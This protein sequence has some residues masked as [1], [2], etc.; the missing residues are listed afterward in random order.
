M[1][2]NLA[3]AKQIEG[4]MTDLEMDWLATIARQSKLVMEVGSFKGRS[5]R[6]I[7]DNLPPEGKLFAIDTWNGSEAEPDAHEACKRLHGDYVYME[8]ISNLS[9]LIYVGRVIP[10]RMH[11]KNAAS[12]LS[13][14]RADFIF[15]DASHL[16]EDVLVDIEAFEPLVAENGVFSGH[17]YS[18]GAHP[19]V[20]KAVDEKL[21]IVNVEGT[22]IWIRLPPPVIVLP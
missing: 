7:A 13:T 22:S 21:K 8:F 4:W 10:L 11:S 19:G 16:Y 6:T 5:T 2:L 18:N 3:R 12:L 9:D 20:S 14:M 1:E 17:D 15:I